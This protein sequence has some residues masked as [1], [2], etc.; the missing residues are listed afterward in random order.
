M[1]LLQQLL[2]RKPP[3]GHLLLSEVAALP[4]Y[5]IQIT[6][7]S[8]AHHDGKEPVSVTLTVEVALAQPL[9]QAKGK[10]TSGPGSACIQTYTSDMDFIDFRRVP[11]VFYPVSPRN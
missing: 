5:R 3:F 11:C 9:G 8:I 4:A 7:E 6:E 2:N 1:H 10:R